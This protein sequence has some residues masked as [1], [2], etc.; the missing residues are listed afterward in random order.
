MFFVL[1]FVLFETPNMRGV[2]NLTNFIDTAAIGFNIDTV[3][4]SIYADVD[5]ARKCY[6]V[7]YGHTST[8]RY[9]RQ[10]IMISRMSVASPTKPHLINKPVVNNT[11]V[12]SMAATLI[13]IA[14]IMIFIPYLLSVSYHSAVYTNKTPLF[15]KESKQHI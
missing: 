10:W 12:Y 4:L 1:E 2:V 11:Y 7:H 9:R 15:V 14:R 3:N 13:V 6:F 5:I 8:T